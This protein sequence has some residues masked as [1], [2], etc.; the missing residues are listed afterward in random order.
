MYLTLDSTV[1]RRLSRDDLVA[2]QAYRTD[3]NV[4]KYQSWQMMDDAETHS[5]LEHM[6]T[7]TPLMRPGNWT[8]IAVAQ[9]SSDSL[10]GDMGLHLSA[11]SEEAE[12]GITLATDSQGKGH[13]TRAVEMATAWL[14]D[15]TPITRIHAWADIR[16]VPSRRLLERAGFN[17]IRIEVTNG[18]TEA[19]FVMNRARS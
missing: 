13:A 6:A 1:L 16:N 5:F 7:T 18:V 19:A 14:F 3:P 12:I 2:F 15:T 17:Q 9:K 10:L 4:A 11:D 8:Q